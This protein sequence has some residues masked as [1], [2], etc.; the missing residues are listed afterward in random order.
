M[1]RAVRALE[2]RNR[3]EFYWDYGLRLG[4]AEAVLACDLYG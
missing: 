4:H 3:R 1:S 2:A